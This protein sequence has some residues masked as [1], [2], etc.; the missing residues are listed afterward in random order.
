MKREIIIIINYLEVLRKFFSGE[1]EFDIVR[2]SLSSVI[3]SS[4]LCL[5]KAVERRAGRWLVELSSEEEEG[6]LASVPIGEIFLKQ[7]KKGGSFWNEDDDRL[8]KFLNIGV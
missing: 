5:D 8:G 1:V 3:L 7:M 6:D 4:S 2:P